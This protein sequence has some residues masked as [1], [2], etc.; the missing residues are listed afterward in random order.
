MNLF[1]FLSL[2]FEF[3][4][5]QRAQIVSNKSLVKAQIANRALFEPS[6]LHQALIWHDL[7]PL[8]YHKFKIQTQENNKVS[9]F[10]KIT[11]ASVPSEYKPS[12]AFILEKSLNH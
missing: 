10:E 4:I 9:L 12:L 1:I 7:R 2:N 11:N 8:K 6:E 3:L 5:F